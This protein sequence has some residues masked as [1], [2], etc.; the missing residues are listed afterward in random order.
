MGASQALD[1]VTKEE[2]VTTKVANKED[3]EV[4]Q[5]LDRVKEG[6]V[7]TKVVSMEE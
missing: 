4:S 2:G 5:A 7:T 6:E 1:T 3:L